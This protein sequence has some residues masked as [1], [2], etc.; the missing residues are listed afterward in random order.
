MTEKERQAFCFFAGFWLG[1][2]IMVI[3]VIIAG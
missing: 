1:I 3:M 2:F